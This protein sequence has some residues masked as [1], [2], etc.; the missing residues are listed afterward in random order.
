VEYPWYPCQHCVNPKNASSVRTTATS[1]LSYS[2]VSGHLSSPM[3]SS[4]IPRIISGTFAGPY[5][6]VPSVLLISCGLLAFISVPTWSRW[7][8]ALCTQRSHKPRLQTQDNTL[9]DTETTSSAGEDNAVSEDGDALSGD[10][11]RSG[12]LHFLPLWSPWRRSRLRDE[13]RPPP[14]EGPIH[15]LCDN[16]NAAIE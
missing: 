10:R 6:A 15:I 16:S 3:P 4:T 2:A 8:S 14:A 5:R 9:L 13:S 12:W 1:P 11:G 7:I